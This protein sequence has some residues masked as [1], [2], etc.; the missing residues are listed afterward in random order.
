MTA[1]FPFFFAFLIFVGFFAL[2]AKRGVLSLLASGISLASALVVFLLGMKLLPDLALQYGEI[3]LE[4]KKTAMISGAA[5]AIVFLLVRIIGGWI[6][7]SILGP[8]GFMHSLVDGVAGGFIS[9]FPSLIVVL[10]LFT[11]IRISGT[12]HELNYAASLSRDKVATMADQIPAYPWTAKWRDGVEN[13]PFMPMV[14]DSVDP[15][16]NRANR[17]AAAFAIMNQ[18]SLVRSHLLGL[19]DTAKL[20][21]DERII[22]INQNTGVNKALQAQ[23]RVGLVFEPHIRELAAAPELAR[24]FQRVHL[25]SVLESYVKTLKGSES[26]AQ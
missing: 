11:C 6:L 24:L 25:R 16:S 26:S 12:L 8:E 15:F 4:W 22:T 18:S 20:A 9:L 2:S 14:L 5:A 10:F 7:K 23:E 1:S 21:A 19:P 13:I 3:E 17:N